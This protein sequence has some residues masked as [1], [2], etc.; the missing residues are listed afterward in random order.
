[1]WQPNPGHT[2]INTVMS[3]D[4]RYATIADDV[5]SALDIM[6][7][8]GVRHLPVIEEG[9][10]IGIVSMRVLRRPAPR[11]TA[12]VGDGKHSTPVLSGLVSNKTDVPMRADAAT[13]HGD[14]RR[15]GSPALVSLPAAHAADWCRVTQSSRMT[16]DVP[17]T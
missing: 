16:G 17:T 10:I 8:A 1:M 7:V 4:P 12:R 9:E 11:A 3:G 6:I 13:T 14:R 2:V 15:P 5:G